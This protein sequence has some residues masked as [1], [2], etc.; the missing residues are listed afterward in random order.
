M[1]CMHVLYPH[2]TICVEE[3]IKGEGKK[4]IGFNHFAKK[5]FVLSQELKTNKEILIISLV[6]LL[7]SQI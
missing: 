3:S 5:Y 7:V 6:L 1:H 2:M 4:E